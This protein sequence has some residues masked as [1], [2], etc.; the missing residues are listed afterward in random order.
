MGLTGGPNPLVEA[1]RG[2]PPDSVRQALTVG[3]AEFPY[4][5]KKRL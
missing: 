1:L 4:A 5:G 2:I 3:K